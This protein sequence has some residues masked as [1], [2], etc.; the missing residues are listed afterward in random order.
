MTA[1]LTKIIKES[2][3]NLQAS[4]SSPEELLKQ[5]LEATPLGILVIDG[6]ATILYVNDSLCRSFGYLADEL[7]GQP[8][9]ILVPESLATEH[10][11]LR[12]SYLAAPVQ[13][14]MQGRTVRGR[15]KN[16]TEIPV[17]IGLNPLDHEQ[18]LKVACTVM[19]LSACQRLEDT[20]AN[21][22]ELSL[23]LF[24]IANAE[25]YFIRVNPNFPRLLRYPEHELLNRPYLDFVHPEDK[26]VTL[27]AMGQLKSGEPVVRFRNRY[28]TNGGEYLWLEW[29]ARV[30]SSEGVI[31][32]VARDVT[33]EVDYQRELL[34]RERRE[35]TILENTP[36]VIFVKDLEGRYLYVNQRFTDLFSISSES[37]LGKTD[38]QIFPTPLAE[39]FRHNDRRVVMT[40][41]KITTNEIASHKGD[42]RNYISVKFPLFDG[43]GKVSAVAGISTDITD[44]LKKQQLDNELRLAI[45]FQQKLYPAVAPSIVGLDIFGSAIPASQMCGDYYDFI[46]TDGPHVVI[47]VGDVSGHGLG[48]ALAMVEVRSIIRSMVRHGSQIKL[49]D[50]LQRLN[51]F[52]LQDLPEESFVSL[53]LVDIDRERGELTYAG[54]GHEA[55]LLPANGPYQILENTAPVVGLLNNFTV[56]EAPTIPFREGDTLL[57]YTDGV[58]EARNLDCD[59]FGTRR[60]TETLTALR[61]ENSAEIIHQLFAKVL[62]FTGHRS[63]KDDMTAVAVKVIPLVPLSPA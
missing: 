22:F 25:G 54:A 37:V 12:N 28:R 40:Q 36:V 21:F 35:Q 26:M 10:V 1:S 20:L 18:G 44:D 43:Q 19:D 41:G 47:A 61:G 48:P 51:E 46:P 45:A 32:A 63:V 49:T 60:V 50:I 39:A 9:E 8:I 2:L 38:F 6:D 57:I 27:S 30:V 59:L 13:R 31:Y 53:F 15:R 33:G 16:G 55:V 62:E 42:L 58:T 17:A 14:L 4:I 29:N 52:L 23:D 56:S 7:I 3:S 24:C 5:Y 11:Q 34:A